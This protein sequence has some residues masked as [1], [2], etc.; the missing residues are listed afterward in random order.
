M[1][2]PFP[3]PPISPCCYT[4]ADVDKLVQSAVEQAQAPLLDV[5]D[6]LL[7]EIDRLSE[8][9]LSLGVSTGENDAQ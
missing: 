5:I 1:F 8:V 7:T 4:Q 2:P 6:N 9:I 3:L